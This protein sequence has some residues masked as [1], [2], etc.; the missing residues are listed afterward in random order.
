M[1][2]ADCG[3]QGEEA[4]G[5]EGPGDQAAGPQPDLGK[6][7][8]F[9]FLSFQF[10]LELLIQ[11]VSCFVTPSTAALSNR[12]PASAVMCCDSCCTQGHYKRDAYYFLVSPHPSRL[13]LCVVLNHLNPVPNFY[14]F[15]NPKVFKNFVRIYI[16]VLM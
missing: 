15:C 3:G 2:Q 4:A 1:V 7:F 16:T 10:P 11:T 8:F 12:K 14:K 13:L 6:N 9:F 5:A